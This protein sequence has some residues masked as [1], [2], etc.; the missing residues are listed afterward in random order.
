MR[1][2]TITALATTVA[3]GGALAMA[4]GVANPAQAALAAGP[5]AGTKSVTVCVSGPDGTP[6]AHNRV[7]ALSGKKHHYTLRS[8]V[9]TGPDG[10]ATVAVG[11]TGKVLVRAV[12]QSEQKIR[13][14]V[15]LRS[16]YR[17]TWPVADA[18]AISDG[19]TLS[20]QLR[21]V[22]VVAHRCA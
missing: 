7:I 12:H 9:Q 14:H 8:S 5:A 2:R 4:V 13:P 17:H 10:C 15:C 18:S 1:T 11:S 20:G 22:K 21:L 6:F 16:V 19:S 3:V